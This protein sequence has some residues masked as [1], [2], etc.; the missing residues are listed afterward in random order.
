MPNGQPS[1]GERGMG[2]GGGG[3]GGSGGLI[4]AAQPQDLV[5]AHL[6][7]SVAA[8]RLH[9]APVLHRVLRQLPSRR[10]SQHRGVILL[11]KHTC[12]VADGNPV[13]GKEGKPSA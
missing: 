3:V 10:G 13:T 11:L 7:L 4:Q 6:Y 9:V 12:L 8:P 2:S 1:L 5:C